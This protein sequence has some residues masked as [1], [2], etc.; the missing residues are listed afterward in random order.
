MYILAA[1]Y[2]IVVVNSANRV[3]ATVP[4]SPYTYY[5]AYNPAD[6]EVYVANFENNSISILSS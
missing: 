6:R 3:V 2:D 1:P 4:A 5:G